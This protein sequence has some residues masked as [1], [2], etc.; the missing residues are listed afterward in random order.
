MISIQRGKTRKLYAYLER[1]NRV[2]GFHLDR[3]HQLVG[4]H[5]RNSILVAIHLIICFLFTNCSYSKN[6]TTATILFL[7]P[8]CGTR[9]SYPPHPPVFLRKKH[10]TIE[11]QTT[12]ESSLPSYDCGLTNIYSKWMLTLKFVFTL[13]IIIISNIMNSRL[14]LCFKRT[15]VF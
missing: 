8:C 10:R 12:Y 11:M 5:R 13:S 6:E 3:F 14:Q 4:L 15:S 2:D 9:Q 7:Y 1:E